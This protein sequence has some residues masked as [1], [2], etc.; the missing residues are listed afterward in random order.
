L[1]PAR[2]AELQVVPGPYRSGKALLPAT[3]DGVKARCMLDTGSALTVVES[4]GSFERY[5]AAGS[6]DFKSAGGR[7]QE[8]DTIRIGE[9]RFAGAVFTD[10]PVGRLEDSAENMLGIDL[11]ARQPFSMTFIQVPSLRLNPPAPAHLRAD[12][13][14]SK[15]GLLAVPLTLAGAQVDALW[16]TGASLTVVD[17]VFIQAHPADFKKLGTPMRGTD[18]AGDALVVEVYRARRLSVGGRTFRNTHVVAVDLSLLREHFAQDIQAVLGF[19]V[20]RKADWYFHRANRQWSI[21]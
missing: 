6:V 8:T 2:A 19:N 20:I 15:H 17:P 16:D 13:S 21:R 12:L 9:I 18:G 14:V 5:E 7:Q 10:V 4:D 3:F 1:P 11:I